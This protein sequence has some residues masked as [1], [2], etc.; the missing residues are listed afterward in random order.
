MYKTR[1]SSIK[2]TNDSRMT[3]DPNISF[4]R[5]MYRFKVILLGNVAVGKTSI[6]SQFLDNK[7]LNE[8]TCT[9]SVDF[10][11]K[12][13]LLDE[14]LIVDLQIW[15]TCGQETYRTLTKQYYRDAQGIKCII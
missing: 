4:E 8:Y 2:N 14:N 3:I 5:E 15:D 12:S 9:I 11:V 6:I 13:L 10:K 1:F 7:F